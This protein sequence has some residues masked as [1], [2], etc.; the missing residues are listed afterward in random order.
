MGKRGVGGA[1]TAVMNDTGEVGLVASTAKGQKA[2]GIG[3]GTRRTRLKD[4]AKK[5]G[6]GLWT[7]RLG[8][9][10]AV[11]VAHGPKVRAVAVT[12][13]K[14]AQ[15]KVAEALPAAGPA[16]GPPRPANVSRTAS[17]RDRPH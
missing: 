10:K 4:R 12:T 6:G 2:K 9:A 16:R 7:K 1:Q 15:A 13:R 5:I 14:T 3:P 8:K 17:S 11:Y